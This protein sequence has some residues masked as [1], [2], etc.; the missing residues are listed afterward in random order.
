[1]DGNKDIYWNEFFEGYPKLSK[2]DHKAWMAEHD[3]M[4]TTFAEHPTLNNLT[5]PDIW[6]DRAKFYF[7][8]FLVNCYKF[9][10]QHELPH[11]AI[12][13]SPTCMFYRDRLHL[14]NFMDTIHQTFFRAMD[15]CIPKGEKIMLLVEKRFHIDN[16]IDGGTQQLYNMLW[17]YDLSGIVNGTRMDQPS[18]VILPPRYAEST[19]SMRLGVP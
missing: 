3:R 5:R 2:E 1:M 9:T 15:M 6:L 12:P 19:R 13:V 14:R 8:P 16:P 18:K 11:F 17:D 4:K 10:R 7:L